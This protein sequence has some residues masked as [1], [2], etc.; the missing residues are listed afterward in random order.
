VPA[1]NQAVT[2][3]NRDSLQTVLLSLVGALATGI[4]GL[5]F[6]T[7]VGGSVLVARFRGAGLSGTTAVSVVPKSDLL[8]IGIDQLLAPLVVAFGLVLV[9]AVSYPRIG[10]T[11]GRWGRLAM[12]T[13]IAVV[14]LLYYRLQ[15][16]PPLGGSHQHRLLLGA[17]IVILITGTLATD[18]LGER[19]I[20]AS[21]ANLLRCQ[22]AFATAVFAAVLAFAS[23]QTYAIN[24][25]HPEVRAGAL[26]VKGTGEAVAGLYV[27]QTSDRVWIGKANAGRKVPTRGVRSTGRL[28]GVP[29]SAVAAV[30][31]GGYEA[32]PKALKKSEALATELKRSELKTIK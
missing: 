26:L 28:I 8:A 13:G 7:F 11:I 31:I 15:V 5:G 1:V 6:F 23:V 20:S 30:S 10:P 24:L 14:A 29:N 27:A 3:P 12:L 16:D 21:P 18:R 32:L 25:S 17:A 22:L 9:L 2:D 19:V 4:G